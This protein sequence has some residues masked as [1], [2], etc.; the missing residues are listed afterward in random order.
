MPPG[1]QDHVEKLAKPLHKRMLTSGEWDRINKRLKRKLDE[2]GWTDDI[3][4]RARG[5][6][7]T[8]LGQ[9]WVD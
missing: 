9:P 1:L 2:S 3:R 7:T 6:S 4:D 5:Q 8:V